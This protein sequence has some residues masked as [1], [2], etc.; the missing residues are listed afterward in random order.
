MTKTSQYAK[1]ILDVSPWPSGLGF[2]ESETWWA[3]VLDQSE[4]DRLDFLVTIALLSEEVTLLLLTHNRALLDRFEFTQPM[5]AFLSEIEA[6][7]LDEFA[8]ALI[9]KRTSS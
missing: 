8:R 4:E 6:T 3:Y 5:I 9:L 7:S 1:A 2:E